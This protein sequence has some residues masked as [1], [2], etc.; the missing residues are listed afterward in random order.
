MGGQGVASR[1]PQEPLIAHGN[2]D[3]RHR[4]AVDP[5]VQTLWTNLVRN[6][7]AKIEFLPADV[8]DFILKNAV[9]RCTTPTT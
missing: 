7:G 4:L 3:H 1:P 9:T 5:Q 2:E 6:I 8:T